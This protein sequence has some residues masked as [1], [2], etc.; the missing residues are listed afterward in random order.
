YVEETVDQVEVGAPGVSGSS[1]DVAG[2]NR[3]LN[4]LLQSQLWTETSGGSYADAKAQLYQQLQQVYGTPGTPG[5][6]D[7]A[8]NN[9]TSALQAL[10]TS[11]ASYSAQSAVLS[12]AQQL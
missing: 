9:F 12:T 3:N 6:F 4:T 11:P 5:A 10:S 7:S 2:I 8:F 1:V